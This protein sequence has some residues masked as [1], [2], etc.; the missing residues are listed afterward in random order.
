M[1][2]LHKDESNETD[3]LSD[4]ELI[5]LDIIALLKDNHNAANQLL[6]RLQLNRLGLSHEIVSDGRAAIERLASGDY[7]A[8]LMDC[9]MPLLDGYE[10]T[11]QI[12]AGAAGVRQ[13]KIPIIALTAHAMA[14][15]REKCLASGMDEYLSKPIRLEELQQVLQSLGVVSLKSETPEKPAK[16]PVSAVLEPAQLAQLS[17]LPGRQGSAL[18]DDLVAMALQEVPADI[19]RLHAL[20]EQRTGAELVQLAHRLAGSAASLGAVSLR[21]TLQAME[22]AGRKGDWSD[23]ESL[24]PGLDHQ[25]HLVRDALQKLSHT[26]RT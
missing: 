21:V 19:V 12:R 24:R 23:A 6:I 7:A 22:Q 14:S 11:Q 2:I 9:Q 18:L 5:A 25:W 26:P 4:L 15:D 3:V 10:T 16:T 13:P 17:A 20:V 8:V 1:D